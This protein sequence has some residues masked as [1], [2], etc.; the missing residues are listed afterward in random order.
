MRPGTTGRYVNRPRW[1]LPKSGSARSISPDIAQGF[2]SQNLDN[3]NLQGMCLVGSLRRQALQL[4]REARHVDAVA[5]RVAF[6]GS[7]RHLKKIRDIGED[8]LLGKRQVLLEDLILLV[9]L[10]KIDEDL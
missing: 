9:A 7:V 8:A 6:I 4:E 2:F 3:R 5:R 10:R 1:R